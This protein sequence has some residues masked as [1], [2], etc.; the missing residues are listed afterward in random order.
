M[1]ELKDL[2]IAFSDKFLLKNVTSS[3]E[4]SQL[5]ALLGR[6]GSGKST[7]LKVI[8]GLSI[9]YKGTVLIDNQNIKDFSKDSFSKKL[10]YVN[11]KRP[12]F[13]NLK[14]YDVVALG[15]SP[16]TSWHAGLSSK[17]KEIIDNSLIQVGMIDYK[18][19]DFNSLSDGESQKIMIARAIAQQT[20]IILLDEP[21]SFLDLPSR[22]E[23]VELLKTMAHNNKLI[24]YSTHDLDAA[25]ELSDKIAVIDNK[26]LY[27]LPIEEMVSSG[28]IQHLFQTNNKYID[29]LLN[30]IITT[31]K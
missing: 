13:T 11:T 12:F 30:M 7:L 28:H 9:N 26:K 2:N 22:F 1:I 6:N 8:C 3:F 27:N 29:R 25:V 31:R 14:C 15:R 19:R 4:D 18:N 17:D 21:T 16:Y 5:T 24:L 20:D 23:L 10:A